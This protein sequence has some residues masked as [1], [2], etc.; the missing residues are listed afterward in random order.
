MRTRR[1][2]APARAPARPRPGRRAVRLRHLLAAARTSL[3]RVIVPEPL[4]A[5]WAPFARSA[6]AA[7]ERRERFDCVIT[8]S[9]PESVHA[10]GRALRAARRPLG[11]RPP[12]RLDLRADPAAAFP[13]RLQRRLDERL[14]RRWLGAADAVVCVSRPAA[15]DLR[16]RLGIEPRLVPNGWD[17]DLIAPSGAGERR[18]ASSTPSGSR[19]S[20]PGASAATGAI[21]RPL[22]ERPGASSAASDPE[23]ASRLELVVAGPADRGRGRADGDRRLPGP[24]RG[25]RQPDPRARARPAAR[26]R[27]AA[28]ARLARSAPSCSTSSCSSTWPRDGRSWRSPPA[29][30]RGGWSPSWAARW[31]RPTT[32]RRSS[33]RCAGSSPASCGPPTRRARQAYSYP[34]AAERLAEVAEARGGVAPVPAA[35]PYP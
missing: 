3:S 18:P 16:E 23:A 10:V 15:E 25:R 34:A 13:P 20:T 14:E 27:R 26:G 30:R 29:P 32:W 5:A 33:R 7:A 24:D 2:A 12:R 11:R 31:C 4:V 21:P 35:R 17:P 8:S 9:P 22:V 6:G 28:A 19:S 1:P